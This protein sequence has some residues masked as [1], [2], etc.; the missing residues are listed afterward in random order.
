LTLADLLARAHVTKWDC[1]V[2]FR[3]CTLKGTVL[4]VPDRDAASFIRNCFLPQLREQMPE[5]EL[6]AQ[7]MIETPKPRG[8]VP[9][10]KQKRYQV[11]RQAEAQRLQEFD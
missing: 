2:W 7:T 10:S 1:A 6:L 11:W 3:G 4:I 5:L 8:I 9:A